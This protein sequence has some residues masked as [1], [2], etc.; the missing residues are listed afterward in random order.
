ME[1][2]ES[3]RKLIRNKIVQFSFSTE[4][5]NKNYIDR[6]EE[7]FFD[8]RLT[9]STEIDNIKKKSL[10]QKFFDH[11][12]ISKL[13]YDDRM[14]LNNLF[15]NYIKGDV[16]SPSLKKLQNQN[17]KNI[18]KN[19]NMRIRSYSF[20]HFDTDRLTNVFTFQNLIKSAL[21]KVF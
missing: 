2:L 16:F 8:S 11:M 1:F 12:S 18:K 20:E 6:L 13:F 10:S 17:S 7:F 5:M 19:N 3:S 9:E 4:D 14:K 21:R 15:L